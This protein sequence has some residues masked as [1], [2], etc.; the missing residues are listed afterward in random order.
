VDAVVDEPARP[1]RGGPAVD[2]HVRIARQFPD[3][4][5]IPGDHVLLGV[6]AAGDQGLD[7]DPQ[8][9]LVPDHGHHLLDPLDQAD[10]RPGGDVGG[11][12]GAER[13]DPAAPVA[14]GDD[15]LRHRV[16]VLLAGQSLG[17]RAAARDLHVL[18]DDADRRVPGGDALGLVRQV[19]GGRQAL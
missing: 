19:V 14:A 12:V 15:L 7:V 4:R 6:G 8:R 3:E 2:P 16:G 9:R 17:D 18:A 1:H 11:V 13:E 10:V 5:L